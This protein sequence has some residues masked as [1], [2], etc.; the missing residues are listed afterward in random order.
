MRT[1]SLVRTLTHKDI[2][3]FAIMSLDED[4]QKPFHV[5][6]HGGAAHC[7]PTVLGTKAMH[8]H[9]PVAAD[10]TIPVALGRYHHP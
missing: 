5:V 6:A 3:V 1:A 7:S 9:R 10:S 4:F 8:L 2:E